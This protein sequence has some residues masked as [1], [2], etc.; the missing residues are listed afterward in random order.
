MK[1]ATTSPRGIKDWKW[2]TANIGIATGKASGVVVIDVD[3]RAGGYVELSK[4]IAR[5]GKLPKGPTA[6]TGGR[7]LHLYF[8]YPGHKLRGKAAEGI[9]VKSD[10]GYVV[11]P[12]S[13]P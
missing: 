12:P 13:P 10:G 2:E 9:D 7:G 5:L 11:A 3:P 6:F 8:K 4:L 1:A